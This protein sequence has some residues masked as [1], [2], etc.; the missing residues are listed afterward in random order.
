MF[1][2]NRISNDFV[3]QNIPEMEIKVVSNGI[4]EN[5]EKASKLHCEHASLQLRLW[6]DINVNG[7]K[8]F[9]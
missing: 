5:E 7:V 6:D 3:A 8:H 4:L 2:S 1:D 9:L